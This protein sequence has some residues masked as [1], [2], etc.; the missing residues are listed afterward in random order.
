MREDGPYRKLKEGAGET[1]E[2]G[3]RVFFS[4][5]AV[6][7][8]RDED[9]CGRERWAG[10][11]SS[12]AKAGCGERE[13]SASLREGEMELEGIAASSPGT[14]TLAIER[15]KD[16]GRGSLKPGNRLRRGKLK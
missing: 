7:R 16:K 5:L 6:A 10:G 2:I 1:K 11:E 8:G 4:L 14:S 3:W 12:D 9:L 15:G 13:R